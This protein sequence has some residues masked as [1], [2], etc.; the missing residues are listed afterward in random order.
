MKAGVRLAPD[1]RTCRANEGTE[2]A[3]VGG[4]MKR[5]TRIVVE[6]ERLLV[7][8]RRRG[9]YEGS[10]GECGGSAR[11]VGLDEAASVSGLS[12]REIVRQVEAGSLHFEESARGTLLVC[13]A[14]LLG[15][16]TAKGALE[17]S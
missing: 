13:L 11:L 2:A 12:Q 4:G 6:T 3:P 5:R 8:R 16:T 1:A 17:K 7:V 10:C 15:G 14:S 9:Q